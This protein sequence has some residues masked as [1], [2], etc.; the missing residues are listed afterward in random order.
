MAVDGDV[1]LGHVS[2][3][4]GELGK[5]GLGLGV[6]VSLV[7][8]EENTAV[9]GNLDGLEAVG[10]LDGLDGGCLESCKFGCLLVHLLADDGTCGGTDCGSDGCADGGGLAILT[11]KGSNACT[12]SGAC[13]GSDQGILSHL[14]HGGA[15]GEDHGSAKEECNVLFHL[16]VIFRIS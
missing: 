14:G 16:S 4:G 7:E 11:D 12:E 1:G 5:I 6:Q 2:H 15:S 3:L 8:G 13:T 10:I 9:E